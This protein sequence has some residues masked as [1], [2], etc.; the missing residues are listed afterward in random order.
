MLG[1]SDGGLREE[2]ARILAREGYA[3]LALAYFG[4]EPLTE[5]LV[6]I[7][8]EY[9]ARAIA[10]LKEQPVVDNERI[11]ILGNSKGGELALLLG[12][13]YA[14]DLK[15][16]IAYAPSGVVWQ[17]ISSRRK[18]RIPRSSW[19]LEG[20]PIPFVHFARPGLKEM[21]GFAGFAF[22]RAISLRS[23]YA[24]ALWNEKAV[25]DAEIPV[26]R[27]QGPVLLISGGDDEMWPSTEMAETVMNRL[28]KYN[29]PYPYEHLA[30]EE[31]GHMITVP[32]AAPNV[33]EM[34][35]FKLGGNERANDEARTDSWKKVLDFL[36]NSFG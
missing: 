14:N 26:E 27:I 13:I 2:S 11:A 8:L 21:I 31:A 1:G 3:A 36:A 22:G 15:E 18:A 29:H 32:G 19:T 6:E 34:G 7:P 12:A 25:V 28:A 5:E 24:K 20:M 9:F 16:V 30:Y 4:V 23:V 17:G 35:R 10:W 33:T